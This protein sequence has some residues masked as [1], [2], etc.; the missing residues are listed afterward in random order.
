M[1]KIQGHFKSHIQIPKSVLEG[2]STSKKIVNDKGFTETP[3]TIFAM[4]MEGNISEQNIK[5]ANTRFGYFEDPIEKEY[6][7]II[8][9]AFG[10]I[11]KKIKQVIKNKNSADVEITLTEENILAVK[12]YCALCT[13]RSEKFVEDIKQKSIFLDMLGNAPQNVALYQY[14]RH[15]EIIDKWFSSLNL[16]FLTND[17]KSNLILPQCGILI[18]DKEQKSKYDVI[19]PVAP[20]LGFLLT[21]DDVMDNALWKV[22]RLSIEEIDKLN[23]FAID[24]EFQYN[25]K[26]IYAKTMQDLEKYRTWL[27]RNRK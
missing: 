8:E 17:T 27:L 22:G 13:V 7:P 25:H 24:I 6:L 9:S 23:K 20:N 10:D 11:K 5:D 12:K 19:I 2:F 14:A 21:E 16:S 3:K 15:P 26:A 18:L 1:D 4:D